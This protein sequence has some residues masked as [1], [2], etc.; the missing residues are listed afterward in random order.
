MANL[1]DKYFWQELRRQTSLDG[2]V[3]IEEAAV[4]CDEALAVLPK[5]HGFRTVTGFASGDE[6]RQY[7][8][9]INAH[10][11]LA[12]R[13]HDGVF[14]ADGTAGQEERSY[15]LGYYGL[16]KD[17]PARLRLFY[18]DGVRRSKM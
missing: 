6:V 4:W 10:S 14:I 11:V 13:Y 12:S 3:G 5:G 15:P 2:R 8:L 17:A 7:A 18:V 9:F 1:R 16:L